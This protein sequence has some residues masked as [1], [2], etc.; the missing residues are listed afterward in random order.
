[1]KKSELDPRD[2]RIKELEKEKGELEGIRAQKKNAEEKYKRLEVKLVSLEADRNMLKERFEN[3]KNMYA[4]V[5]DFE[6]R[7]KNIK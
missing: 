4:G 5:E 3:L 1:M 7:Q 6:K 2:E